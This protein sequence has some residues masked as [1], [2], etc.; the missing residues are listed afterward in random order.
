MQ[1]LCSICEQESTRI[2]VNC[3]KDACSNHICGRCGSCSD[4]CDCE[5]PL[6]GPEVTHLQVET[7]VVEQTMVE[8]L[9]VLEE[10]TV[11]ESATAAA[12]DLTTLH[13]V[14]RQESDEDAEEEPF[15]TSENNSGF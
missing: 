12:P 14:P 6:D 10:T 5:V 8:E 9:G 7:I 4:C 11:V 2:C 13:S 3:T 15:P 1:F